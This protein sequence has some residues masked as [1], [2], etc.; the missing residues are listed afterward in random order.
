MTNQ[1]SVPD[2]L[3]R[4]ASASDCPPQVPDHELIR[5]VGEGS[6]GSVWLARNIMG[7]FRAVK[8]VHRKDFAD[9][10][11]FEREFS[12]IRKFE[13]ISRSHDGFVDILQIGRNDSEGYFYY[14]MELADDA[15]ALVLDVQQASSPAA[16]AI[17]SYRPCTLRTEIERQGRLPAAKCISIGLSLSSALQHLHKNGLVHRDIKPSNIIFVN[18]QPKLADIGLVTE[19]SDARSFVGTEGFIPPEGP[20]TAQADIYSLGKVLYEIGSGKDR[21]SF[22]EPPTR[23]GDLSDRDALLE[24]DAVI[25]KACQPDLSQRYRSATEMHNDLLLL[26]AGSSVRDKQTLARRLRFMTRLAIAAASVL[27]LA[28]VPYGLA[29]KEA[30]RAKRAEADANEKLWG[31]YLAQARAQ[32]AGREIGRRFDGLEALKKAAALKPTLQLRNQAITCLALPDMR[33]VAEWAPPEGTIS[34]GIFDSDCQ[35]YAHGDE[36]GNISIRAVRSR[37]ELTRLPG[38]G[39]SVHEF[40]FSPDGRYLS[41]SYNLPNKPLWLWDL[42]TK[43][44]VLKLDLTSFR[45][46]DFT[47]DSARIAVAQASG[48]VLLYDISLRKELQRIEPV[49]MP[50]SLAFDPKGHRLGITSSESPVV[51]IL[52]AES[53]ATRLSLIHSNG[54]FGLAWDPQGQRLATGCRDGHVYVWDASN[55]KLQ[56]FLDRGQAADIHVC[57]SRSSD[58]LF[59]TCWDGYLHMWSTLTG[60]EICRGPF[61]GYKLFLNRNGDHLGY[62]LTGNKLGLA[63]VTL[64]NECRLLGIADRSIDSGRCS[65]SP[66]GCVL[67]SAHPDGVRFW[68][69]AGGGLVG[70]KAVG[71]VNFLAFHPTSGALLFGGANGLGA[72]PA[73]CLTNAVT[74]DVSLGEIVFI[75]PEAKFGRH[76]TISIGPTG[77]TILFPKAGKIRSFDWASRTE[78]DAIAAGSSAEFAVLSGNGQ[79]CAAGSEAEGVTVWE[80]QT[81]KKLGSFPARGVTVVAFSGDNRLLGIGSAQTYWFYHTDTWQSPVTITRDKSGNLPGV[82]A[83]S[84]DSRLA[85]IAY[86]AQDIRLVE[87]ATGNEVATLRSP[88]PANIGALAFSPRGDQLAASRWDHTIALWDLGLIRKELTEMKLNWDLPAL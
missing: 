79:W 61:E 21:R 20:G 78:S 87:P 73:K 45:T 57:F 58:L 60:E 9:E 81:R 3:A 52:D 77:K 47:S 67:A 75:D 34:Y 72:L 12:G 35:R 65:F 68:D 14:V 15:A 33:T 86:S 37:Q 62:Q 6:Y 11:P 59:S 55:G 64:G 27:V 8:V 39:A 41:A 70:F 17:D 2:A 85:A 38:P 40:Y 49:A 7:V 16:P 82:L 18:G 1:P 36:A 56:A 46:L 42:A 26:E 84:P 53:G 66:D 19:S 23:I 13:P 51:S 31:S 83:F 5:R 54:V 44:V 80:V 88:D 71:S 74:P 4:A 48:P 63:E 50:Y 76:T 10:R 69:A 25:A 30:A 28:V 22:P 43:Q 29:L 24:L 32:E